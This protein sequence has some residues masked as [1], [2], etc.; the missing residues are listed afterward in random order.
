MGRDDFLRAMVLQR[1]ATTT[2]ARDLL[3]TAL[4]RQLWER[5]QVE[6]KISK[7]VLLRHGQSEWNKVPTFTG[8]TDVGLTERGRREA[9]G[10][11]DLLL[12]RGYGKITAAFTS[13]LRRAW[14][15]LDI[16]LDCLR[17]AVPAQRDW[18]LNERHYGALQGIPKRDEKLLKK[19]GEEQIVEWRRSL[20]GRPPPLEP[21]PEFGPATESL[22]DCRDRV[23]KCFEESIKPSLCQKPG[24]LVLLVAH[25][26]TVRGLQ[27]YLDDAPEAEIPGLHVPN[28]VPIIYDFDVRTGNPVSNTKATSKARWLLSPENQAKIAKALQ[29]GGILTRALFDSW[30]LNRDEILD[31]DELTHG[32]KTVE[33]DVSLL[34]IA[35]RIVRRVELE[36]HGTVTLAQWDQLA[37]DVC[38][39][40]LFEESSVKQEHVHHFHGH[41]DHNH[42]N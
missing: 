25:S 19:Y 6:Q 21:A 11:G 28:S 34:A 4:S 16:L 37:S 15:T 29:P 38:D 8:W 7:L 27:S 33:S 14:E 2:T 24:G 39:E 40:L 42:V 1:R 23:V 12:R 20:Y 13:E 41:N 17:V 36:H 35:R 26:N 18:R 3:M 22:A 5:E 31:H 9:R 32:L 10:A 30:D